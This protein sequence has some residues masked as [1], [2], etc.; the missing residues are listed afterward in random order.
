METGLDARQ[1]WDAAGGCCI[2]WVVRLGHFGWLRAGSSKDFGRA[3]HERQGGWVPG[4]GRL[5]S[6]RY[7]GGRVGWGRDMVWG[8]GW[9]GCGE[10]DGR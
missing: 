8:V 2:R 3:H 5:G 7:V 4:G 6:G 10:R 9:E 1:G